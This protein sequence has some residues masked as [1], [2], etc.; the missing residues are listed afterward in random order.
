MHSQMFIYW[1]QLDIFIL[2]MQSDS[3]NKHIILDQY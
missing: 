2:L 1:S 3:N